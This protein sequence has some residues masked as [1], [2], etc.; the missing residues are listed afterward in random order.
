MPVVLSAEARKQAV[1]SLGRYCRDELEIEISEIQ[2]TGLLEFVLKEIGPSVYNGA[3]ADA[4]AFVR[5]RLADLDATC[6]Q[7]EFAFWPKGTSV[8]RK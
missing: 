7:P 3:I 5:D 1:A 6:Y 4:Q 8:R 2:V